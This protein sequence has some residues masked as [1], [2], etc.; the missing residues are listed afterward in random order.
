MTSKC[1]AENCSV[2]PFYNL[3]NSVIG[4]YCIKH[5]TDEMIKIV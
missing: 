2:K 3:P 4:I 1:N 5:K